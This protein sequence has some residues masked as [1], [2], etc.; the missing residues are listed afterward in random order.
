MRNLLLILF[1]P[2]LGFSQVGIQTTSPTATLDINGDLRIRTV[3]QVQREAAAKDSILAVDAIGNVQRVT[4]KNVIESH[5]KSFIK[6]TLASGTGNTSITLTS[7]VAT[8]KFTNIEFDLNSEYVPATG[9]FTAKIAGYYHVSIGAKLSPAL[10]ELASPEFGVSIKKGTDI[11]AKS[12]FPNLALLGI[13]VAPPSRFT[14]TLIQ[15]NVGETISF[16]VN[17]GTATLVNQET[18]FTI[19]QVR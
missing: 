10:L 16:E 4:S 3:N 9:I 8:M 2:C 1:F 6:G 11:K 12:S 18:F 17:A 19:Q 13:N 5:F 14:E 7:G 15:L